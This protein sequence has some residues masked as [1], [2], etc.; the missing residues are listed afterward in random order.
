MGTGKSLVSIH[1]AVEND[2]FPCVVVCPA[3]LK[4]T[5]Q[6]EWNKHV[7]MRSFVLEGTRTTRRNP[8]RSNDRVII[9]NYDILHAWRTHLQEIGA[10]LVIADEVHMARS[11]SARRTRELHSLCE[12]VPYVLALSGTPLINRPAEL[13]PT[14]HLL[15]PDKYSSFFAFAMSHCAPKM[16]NGTWDVRGASN[17]QLLHR[18]L[19]R[20][21]MVR[22]EKSEILPDLPQKVRQVIPIE[23]EDRKQYDLAMRDFRGWLKSQGK[24]GYRSS[25]KNAIAQLGHL[26]RLAAKLKRRS[27]EEWVDSFLAESNEKLLLYA[28]HQDVVKHFH[29]RYKGQSVMVNGSVIGR[30]R[31]LAF[32]RFNTDKRC[33][34]FVG[35]IQAAGT[36]WSA[37]GANTVAFAEMDWQPG[38]HAQAEDRV[39][40]INRGEAGKHSAAVYLVARNTIEEKLCD[41]LQRKQEVVSSTLDGRTN[42]KDL[43]VMDLLVQELKRTLK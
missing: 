5:W 33:R 32:D 38:L 41:I 21:C 35:N 43:D 28:V 30:K 20:H 37:K 10:R 22:K 19:K 34:I 1:W 26:K 16:R 7:E 39:H 18:K 4:W 23:I 2:A 24:N 6:T 42:G 31:Q 11:I 8:F 25:K 27:V 36:G 9:V 40:G 17:L 29:Q 12:D 14:L 13:W 15:R 3:S